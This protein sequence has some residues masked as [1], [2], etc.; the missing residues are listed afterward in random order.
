MPERTAF[1]RFRRALVDHGLDQRLFDLVTGQLR[2]RAV[3]VKTGTLVDATVIASASRNDEEA[4]WSGHRTRKTIHGY[5]AHVAA[6]ADTGLVERLDVTPGNVHDGRAGGAVVPENP[7]PVYADSAYRGAAFATAVTAG[8]GDPHC[9]TGRHKTHRRSISEGG[10]SEG[11]CIRC[12]RSRP[13]AS[14]A[15]GRTP[16][17]C[18]AS[19]ARPLISDNHLVRRN[20]RGGRQ[21]T[22]NDAASRSRRCGATC[23]V[24]RYVRDKPTR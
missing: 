11:H 8:G 10:G 3:T 19:Q 13:E 7:G 6:D 21:V 2:A 9:T 24:G 22:P 16:R 15:H 4:H 5:K 23:D 17:A 12:Q 1:V 14:H 18:R 20:R